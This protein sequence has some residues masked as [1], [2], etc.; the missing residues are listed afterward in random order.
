MKISN[1][2]NFTNEEIN[3][4]K[5]ISNFLGLYRRKFHRP[6]N[7]N[8]LISS[9]DRI[10]TEL[11]FVLVPQIG[12][13]E[14]AEKCHHILVR[15]SKN[16]SK[17][18]TGLHISITKY[19]RYYLF[20]MNNINFLNI[21]QF[22]DKIKDYSISNN[23]LIN[24]VHITDSFNS[25]TN[26][27]DTRIKDVFTKSNVKDETNS[28]IATLNTE[29]KLKLENN[30][31]EDR[32]KIEDLLLLIEDETNIKKDTTHNFGNHSD[33][34]CG[35]F[36]RYRIPDTFLTS[37][38]SVDEKET[39]VL[40]KNKRLLIK[41]VSDLSEKVEKLE[42]TLEYRISKNLIILRFIKKNPFKGEYF[43]AR[44]KISPIPAVVSTDGPRG[45]F[46]GIFR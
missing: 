42:Y 10:Y 32:E 22:Y 23:S 8:S 3:I 31:K 34:L 6:E 24:G 17:K 7:I 29:F 25:C 11:Q 19:E 37:G 43:K 18:F 5:G 30:L 4:G 41:L 38:K 35:L 46:G 36:F 12:G 2:N 1:Y 16:V 40:N 45:V 20:Y 21:E 33:D 28:K 14:D 9:F 15:S 27:I 44:N 26:T 39:I 13:G